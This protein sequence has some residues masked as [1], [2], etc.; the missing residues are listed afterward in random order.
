[1]IKNKVTMNNKKLE[2]ALLI[3]ICLEKDNHIKMK[4]VYCDK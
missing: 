1:M 3:I 4:H 2:S